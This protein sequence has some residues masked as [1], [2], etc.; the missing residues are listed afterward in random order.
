VKRPT[1]GI[2][3]INEGK[4]TQVKGTQN[5]FNKIIEENLKNKMPI[6]R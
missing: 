6:K 2:T 1:L 4:E 3:G 5:I